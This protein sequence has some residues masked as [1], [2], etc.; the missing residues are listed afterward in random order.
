MIFIPFMR[1]ATSY[2]GQI[3]HICWSIPYWRYFV[4]GCWPNVYWE[5]DDD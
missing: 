2:E 3:G 1:G 4:L 5:P